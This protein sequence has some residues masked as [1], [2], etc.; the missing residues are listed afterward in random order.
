[1]KRLDENVQ[2]DE[3]TQKLSEK[4]FSRG[5][6]IS[7]LGVLICLAFLCSA[8]WA[9]FSEDTSNISNTITS[10]K[11]GLVVTVCDENNVAFSVTADEKGRSTCTLGPA[12]TYFVTLSVTEDTT[13]TKGF[14]TLTVDGEK[15]QTAVIYTDAAEDFTFFLEL[16]SPNA[17]VT[18]IPAWGIPAS[19]AV[20][21]NGTLSL[22]F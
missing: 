8:T 18:F 20:A 14:C 22:D 6:I 17:V 3:K 13:V 2:I 5:L 7:V 16:S 12:G 4:A 10:G 15:Y 11:F 21:H 9:W 19:P 1:M